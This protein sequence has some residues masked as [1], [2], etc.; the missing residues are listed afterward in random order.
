MKTSKIFSML[1]MA[2]LLFVLPFCAIAE[3]KTVYYDGLNYDINTE[4]KQAVVGQNR[5]AMGKIVIPSEIKYDGEIYTVTEIGWTAFS[6]SKI[7]SVEIEDG[8]SIIGY[9]A[10]SN[11]SLLESVDLPDSITDIAQYAF[12]QCKALK[13]IRFP[14]NLT[15]INS[16]SFSFSGLTTL[17]IPAHIET[18]D[19]QAFGHCKNLKEI[20]IEEGVK[21][22][23]R[24]AFT[25]CDSLTSITIPS[26]VEEINDYAFHSCTSLKSVDILNGNTI[27]GNYIFYDAQQIEKVTLPGSKT[28]N[29]LFAGN[30]IKEVTIPEGTT[31]ITANAF[32]DCITLEKVTLPESLKIIGTSAFDGCTALKE[33]TIPAGVERISLCAFASSGLTDIYCEG[34]LAP[35][36][37]S[38]VGIFPRNAVIHAPEGGQEY[39]QENGWRNVSM[40]TPPVVETPTPTPVS[41]ET[42]TPT[43]KPSVN[44][45]ATPVPTAEPT[46]SPTI[47]PD[48][49][50]ILDEMPKTGDDSH[51]GLWLFA[52]IACGSVLAWM[53][54]RTA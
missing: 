24:N 48:T 26:S 20:V 16:S 33:I 31:K 1:I 28:L 42:P 12:N 7:T 6:G 39:T 36:L 37:D 17:T 15:K 50:V 47:D 3:T 32:L 40:P 29:E 35:M 54:R 46:A 4:T 8:V 52:L 34:L 21:S 13:S 45:T 10:F 22:I 27:F 30:P 38:T 51:I 14:A 18:I 2:M 23:G 19:D 5:S 25:S 9:N 41:I 53:R 11:C 49:T 43:P 44:S